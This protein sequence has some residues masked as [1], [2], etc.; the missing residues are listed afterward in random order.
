MNFTKSCHL[1]TSAADAV[2]EIHDRG[3]DVA[4]LYHFCRHFVAGNANTLGVE[5]SLL[6]CVKLY[7][8]T[9]QVSGI[10]CLK[11]IC[12]KLAALDNICISGTLQY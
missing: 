11:T 6:G 1:R 8:V 7:D 4:I 3:R 5:F 9:F 10:K 12:Q 2:G